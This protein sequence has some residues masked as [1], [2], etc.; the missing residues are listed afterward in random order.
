MG[1]AWAEQRQEGAEPAAAPGQT[2]KTASQAFQAL[3]VSW[4][5]TCSAGRASEEEEA[6]SRQSRL[7]LGESVSVSA[8]GTGMK[9]EQEQVFEA[10]AS[11]ELVEACQ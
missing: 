5:Q 7:T 10:V 11:T 2:V 6:C 8:T 3:L 1:Q 9:Q 4:A